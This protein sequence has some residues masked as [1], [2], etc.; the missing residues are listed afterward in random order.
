MRW[1]IPL[2]AGASLLES[3]A[4][5]GFITGGLHPEL[6][7]VIVVG[8]AALRG[9][10]EGL[11][12]GII[13]GIFVDLMSAAPF[14]VNVVRLGLVGLGAGLVM[15]RVAHGSAL[16]PLAGAAACGSL[17]GFVLSVLALQASGW[18]V[19]WERS[20]LVD[21]LPSAVLAAAGMAIAFPV[22]RAIEQRGLASEESADVLRGE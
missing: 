4:V 3:A 18:S 1:V 20:L 2:L 11:L 10:D 6:S 8:W 16:F 22:L 15:T 5:R 17:V 13:G 14:G 7:L 12:V 19:A 21:A 9:W